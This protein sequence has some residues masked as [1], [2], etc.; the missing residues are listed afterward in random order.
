MCA[1]IEVIISVVVVVVCI[2]VICVGS[3]L[4]LI[5]LIIITN[6]PQ[7]LCYRSPTM[8]KLTSAIQ[9]ILTFI[10]KFTLLLSLSTLSGRSR[11]PTRWWREIMIKL[12]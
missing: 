1:S 10:P 4:L 11:N 7:L 5:I 9:Q 3:L 12:T 8:L 6:I 2:D